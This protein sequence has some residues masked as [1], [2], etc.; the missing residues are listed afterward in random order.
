[1][2]EGLFKIFIL[3]FAEGA[4]S[5]TSTVEIFSAV[6]MWFIPSCPSI[7]QISTKS[8]KILM[9][10]NGYH[11][12]YIDFHIFLDGG[13]NILGTPGTSYQL[14]SNLTCKLPHPRVRNIIN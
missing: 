7:M 8:H 4:S 5:K 14:D 6:M 12:L 2:K 3:Q 10:R 13:I 9:I 1:M 11:Y